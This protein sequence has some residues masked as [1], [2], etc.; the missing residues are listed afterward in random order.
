MVTKLDSLAS[1]EISEVKKMRV[2]HYANIIPNWVKFMRTFGEDGTVRTGKD[3]KVGNCWVT[4]MFVGCAD[5]HEGNC[6]QRF[7]Q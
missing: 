5:N 6:Y 2:E 4:M 7:N 3:G 1:V